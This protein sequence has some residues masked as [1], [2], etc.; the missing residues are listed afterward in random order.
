MQG[1]NSVLEKEVDAKA[2]KDMLSKLSQSLQVGT[3]ELS[4]IAK[5]YAQAI[6]EIAE[7]NNSVSGWSGFLSAATLVIA[8]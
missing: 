1:V 6:F 7:Q 2:H 8:D 3:M 4:T 5:P